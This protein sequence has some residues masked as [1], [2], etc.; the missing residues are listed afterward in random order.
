MLAP[1]EANFIRHIMSIMSI[2]IPLNK[3]PP[4]FIADGPKQ[5]KQALITG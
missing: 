2:C 4:A 5:A 3:K 1:A